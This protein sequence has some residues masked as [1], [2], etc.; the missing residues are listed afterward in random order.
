MSCSSIGGRS[1]EC[2]NAFWGEKSGVKAIQEKQVSPLS[3][4]VSSNGKTETNR[5]H[6]EN[7][8]RRCVPYLPSSGALPPSKSSSRM[9][10]MY[11]QYF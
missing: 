3:S 6:G 4:N 7:A 5:F 9:G 11:I 8:S 1:W 10:T 2:K